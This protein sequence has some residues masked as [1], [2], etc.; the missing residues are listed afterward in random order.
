MLAAWDVGLEGVEDEAA[1]MVVVATQIFL[2][3][4]LSAVLAQ[5]KGYKKKQSFM[6][7]FGTDVP[8]MWLRNT[9][10]II[11]PLEGGRVE[12]GE[13][14]EDLVPRCPPTIDEV[15]HAAALEIACRYVPSLH[16]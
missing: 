12:I 11:D 7:D 2:K 6:Y 8:N 10:K 3:N 1:D 16:F 13:G 9:S 14:T 4:I 15:E 5:R